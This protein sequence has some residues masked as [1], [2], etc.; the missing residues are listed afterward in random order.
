MRGSSKKLNPNKHKEIISIA[1]QAL[2]EAKIELSFGENTGFIAQLISRLK[3]CWYYGWTG[4]FSPNPP[5]FVAAI[6]SPIKQSEK[7]PPIFFN[8]ENISLPN[9]KQICRLSS[10]T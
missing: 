3:R 1:T 2:T 8:K 5:T 10:M 7:K 9:L 4:F 6:D